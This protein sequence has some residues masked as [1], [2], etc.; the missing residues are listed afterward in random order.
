MSYLPKYILK[1]LIPKNAVKL[2]DNMLKVELT[3]IV[4]PVPIG[5]LPGSLRD[6]LTIILDDEVVFSPTKQ[7]LM[8]DVRILVDGEEF[9]ID[10]IKESG[11]GVIML[12]AK[13]TFMV[14]NKFG[15]AIG[16]THK[17]KITADIDP[18]IELEFKR[19]IST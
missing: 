7:E 9:T 8:D 4:S 3:N 16:E 14:P 12:G 2:D 6:I 11:G 1:R 19:E 18:R 15:F 5:E 10:N 17:M 13:L